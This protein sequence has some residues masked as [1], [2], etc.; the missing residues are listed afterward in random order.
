MLKF[1]LFVLSIFALASLL[2][3]SLEDRTFF[4]WLFI[5]ALITYALFE[6]WGWY[7]EKKME[8]L[9]EEIKRTLGLL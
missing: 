5:G 3:G 8:K 2:S 1:G 9:I 6:L 7:E 4:T